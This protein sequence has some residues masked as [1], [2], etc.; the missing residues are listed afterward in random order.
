MKTKTLSC[1][2]QNHEKYISFSMG[3]LDFID[4]F[5][6]LSTSLE[7]LV[8]NLSK[9]GV[10]KFKH[11]HHY[12]EKQHP[13][14]INEKM[15]LLMR[16]GVYPYE[17]MDSI[18]KFREKC[19]PE[20][21]A[22]HSS[23]DD[24][25][26]SEADFYHAQS[27]WKTFEMSDLGDYH[28]LYMET[29]IILLADVFEN[30]RN[31]C[32]RI[33]GLD[34]AHFYT[35]PGLAWQAAL[36][37][38]DVHLELFTDPD[39]HLFIERGLRGGISMISQRYAKANNPYVEDYNHSQP[40]NYLMYLDANN[41]YGWSMS[42]ALTSHGFRW[43]SKE[44]I[45][46]FDIQNISE[47]FKEGYILSVD[48]DYPAE[49]HDLHSD[50]PLAPEPFEVK[51]NMLSSY[52]KEL[53]KELNLLE[54]STRKLVPNLHN[55]TDYVIH[56][57]NLQLYLSLGMKVTKV[58]QVLA[59]QQE[60]WLKKYIDFNT[61]MRKAAK[62]DFEKDFYKLMNNSVFGK[63]MENLRK[64]V[65]I[66]LIHREQRL[67]KVTAKPGF[68]SFKIFNK[69]LASVELTKQNLVL[70]CPIYV[71]F[72]ILEMSK[73]LM[74]HFHYN[75]V[76][77][78][79]GG[80]E[81]LLFTDTDSLCYNIFTEDLYKDLEKVK[82]HFD[83]SDYPSD[84]FLYDDTNKKV[85]GKMK[86]ETMSEPMTEFVGL[87]PKM[88][89]LTYGPTAKGVSKSVIMRHSSYKECLF[90][91]ESH[92][93]TMITFRSEKHQIHT[94]AL[95][96]TSLSPF[97]DKRYILNDGIHTLAHGHWRISHN[98]MTLSI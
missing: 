15:N 66:Q 94:I 23:I 62:N 64:R 92:M 78:T 12:I 84:H 40:N 93:E 46:S 7:K 18:D 55:K 38:T 24:Q 56:Y 58:H 69:D 45:N 75:N 70:N 96:K 31:L 21:S 27:V 76:K 9:E 33:Y 86:D 35:A 72:S 65:D 4:S 10:E 17:Y 51:P 32:L 44:E 53:L 54:T 29:D 90:Q 91:R 6:F 50:Y 28:D 63:T 25:D 16:K 13:G 49:L 42:Q 61:N 30:F 80:N 71:G 11:L 68:K 48:L 60:P 79:Y 34:P 8:K 81:E 41:L 37:M 83:F 85:L 1:I 98:A 39:M 3:K 88:Y 74:Y 77:Y 89:S 73:V 82:H 67:L 26:L 87:R 36:K 43:L 2:P 20:R 19:L 14:Q 97:D 47:D 57:R 95:N 59:F 5:Q 22:F 52:Q